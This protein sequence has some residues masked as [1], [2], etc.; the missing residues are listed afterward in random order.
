MQNFSYHLESRKNLRE[1]ILKYL[2]L[3][4]FTACLSLAITANAEATSYKFSSTASASGNRQIITKLGPNA[5]VTGTFQYDS[6]AIATD[7]TIFY[8]Y[9]NAAVYGLPYKTFFDISGSVGGFTYSDQIGR[10]I[11]GNDMSDYPGRPAGQDWLGLNADPGADF[12]ST[13]LRNSPRNISGFNVGDYKLINVRM[14]WFT[15]INGLGNFLTT[16]TMPSTLP[17][18][19][20]RVALDFVPISN[21]TYLSYNYTV[22]FDGL[23]VQA[24]PVPEPATIILF[25]VGA[26]VIFG[27]LRR[28]LRNDNI[29]RATA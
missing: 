13:S 16:N 18:L 3:G 22:F 7:N 23:Y 27:S 14:F 1:I 6:N 26:V 19:Q 24:Q 15:G 2:R 12:N 29:Q 10:T 21:P 8:G 25:M 9:G 5:K 17:A 11:V 20:G 4:L 28:C